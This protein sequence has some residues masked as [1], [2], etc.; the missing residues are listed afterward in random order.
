MS[1]FKKEM[2]GLFH[3]DNASAGLY[4]LLIGMALG[5]LLPSPSDAVFFSYEKKLRDKWKRGELTAKQFWIKNTASY[6][7]IPFTYW[8]LLAFIVVNIKGDYH[9]KLKVAGALIGAGIALG[10]ILKMMQSDKTQLEKEDEERLLLLKNHPEI[11][12]ILKKPEYENISAQIINSPNDN[13][14]KN[15][16]R[17]YVKLYAEREAERNALYL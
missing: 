14:G 1:D 15:G 2:T 16:E 6:Y 9:K 4:T 17:K 10:V 7:F 8:A 5:N 13:N 11:V 3:G 12:E